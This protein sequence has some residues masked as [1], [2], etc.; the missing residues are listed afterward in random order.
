MDKFCDY[1]SKSRKKIEKISS[2]YKSQPVPTEISNIGLDLYHC[3]SQVQDALDELDR[4]TQGYVYDYLFE[5]AGQG[6][7]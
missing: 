7:A 3:F 5:V 4:Y 2:K 1:I 6:H